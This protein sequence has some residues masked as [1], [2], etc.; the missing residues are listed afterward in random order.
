MKYGHPDDGHQIKSALEQSPR[1]PAHG[2][3]PSTLTT[4]FLWPQPLPAATAASKLP[5]LA[6]E[7]RRHLA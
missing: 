2:L 1:R 6:T 5:G 4:S 3:I 7:N